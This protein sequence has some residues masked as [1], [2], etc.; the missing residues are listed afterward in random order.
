[1]AS[2]SEPRA[3]AQNGWRKSDGIQGKNT[4]KRGGRD[5]KR[6]QSQPGPDVGGAKLG[7]WKTSSDGQMKRA[8]EDGSRS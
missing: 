5:N 1:M 2:D 4:Q 3:S 8:S 6:R 7:D